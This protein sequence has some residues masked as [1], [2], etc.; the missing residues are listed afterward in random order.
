MKKIILVFTLIISAT[1]VFAQEWI[2][3]D[4]E[5]F[6]FSVNL[7]SEPQTMSQEVPTEVGDLTMNMFMV[8]ASADV[9]SK[10]MVYMVIHTDYPKNED[11]P[12]ESKVQNMLDGSVNGAVSNVNGKL[13]YAKNVELNGFPGREVKIEVT[14]AFM[15]MNMYVKD[16]SLY[17]AQV[18]CMADKDENEDIGKFLGSLKLNKVE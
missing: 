2:T 4:S 5:E 3:Y 16:S 6:N 7:P 13:I 1:T 15:Y 9:T 8:D 11:R 17:A 10:N 14:G 18:V 12:E